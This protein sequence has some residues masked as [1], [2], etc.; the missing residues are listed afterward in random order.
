MVI[1]YSSGVV[2]ISG[3]GIALTGNAVSSNFAKEAILVL[4][5]CQV[6]ACIDW[7]SDH[8]RV[9][10]RC[11]EYR[12]PMGV[13]NR[14]LAT[15]NLP[16]RQKTLL[17]EHKAVLYKYLLRMQNENNNMEVWMEVGKVLMLHKRVGLALL[18]HKGMQGY[19]GKTLC[20]HP[21]QR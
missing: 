6:K 19:L 17:S 18:K 10:R 20:I 3:I 5:S 11:P 4:H 9:G 2:I 7:R 8:L 21:Y 13:V 16:L 14:D 12:S 15:H 1:G